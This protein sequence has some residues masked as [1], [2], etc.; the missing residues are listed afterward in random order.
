MSNIEPFR[1]FVFIMLLLSGLGFIALGIA[2]LYLAGWRVRWCGWRGPLVHLERGK[3][4][5][6][7]T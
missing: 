6:G 1:L 7:K 2:M 3:G 4:K 5:G